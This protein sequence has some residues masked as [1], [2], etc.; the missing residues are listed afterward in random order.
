MRFLSNKAEYERSTASYEADIRIFDAEPWAEHEAVDEL[1]A[2]QAQ[3][4]TAEVSDKQ[5]EQQKVGKIYTQM[6]EIEGSIKNHG[7]EAAYALQAAEEFERRGYKSL[8]LERAE[9]FNRAIAAH[10]IVARAQLDMGMYQ[11]GYRSF[12]TALDLRMTISRVL[13]EELSSVDNETIIAR[14]RPLN[15]I[16][17]KTLGEDSVEDGIRLLEKRMLGLIVNEDHD[18][19][20]TWLT[21]YGSRRCAHKLR[22][23]EVAEQSGDYTAGLI[24]VLSRF[25]A[26]YEFP[27]D[28]HDT[29]INDLDSMQDQFG[30]YSFPMMAASAVKNFSNAYKSLLSKQNLKRRNRRLIETTEKIFSSLVNYT[31][32]YDIFSS[33]GAPI[34]LPVRNIRSM[35]EAY[36]KVQARNFGLSNGY[37]NYETPSYYTD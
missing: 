8:G 23:K 35:I 2:L 22:T 14:H 25:L 36:K 34:F 5:V 16:S 33:E 31:V 9:L 6:S 30:P 15:P 4:F 11:L 32:D 18:R 28:M 24:E 19:F 1:I 10:C 7:E 21:R 17:L 27:R 37:T 20:Q 3:V 12:G 13:K 26:V 29:I